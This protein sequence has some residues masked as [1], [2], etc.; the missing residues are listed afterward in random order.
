MLITALSPHIGYDQ[1]AAIAKHA[2]SERIT[3]RQAAVKLGFVTD[4]QFFQWVLP[5][6][7]V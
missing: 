6:K 7:M 1:A 3:L 4:S 2:H 5:E